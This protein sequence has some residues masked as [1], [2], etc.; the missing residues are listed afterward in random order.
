M[1]S[2]SRRIESTQ[3]GM[4]PTGTD[5]RNCAE[6]FASEGV[7]GQ[8]KPSRSRSNPVAESRGAGV[9]PRSPLPGGRPQYA[10][11]KAG[12]VHP[13]VVGG[14]ATD[15]GADK[16]ASIHG[17]A[18]VSGS[19]RTLTVTHDPRIPPADVPP[20]GD[21]SRPLSNAASPGEDV[22]TL[23]VECSWCGKLI[24]EGEPP[25]SHGCCA[26]CKERMLEQIRARRAA[27]ERNAR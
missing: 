8:A 13:E 1:S 5:S 25:I 12:L 10:G 18:S 27:K 2:N 7:E 21:P 22:P 3:R 19:V 9:A 26:E 23:R 17:H 20:E 14:R 15:G 4:V 24:H 11:P 16:F 6:T